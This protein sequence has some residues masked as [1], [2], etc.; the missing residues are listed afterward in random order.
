MDAL[1]WNETEFDS[2]FDVARTDSFGYALAKI[3]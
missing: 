3:N 1:T 2:F